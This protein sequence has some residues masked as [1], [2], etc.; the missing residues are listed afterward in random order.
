MRLRIALVFVLTAVSVHAADESVERSIDRDVWIPFLSASTAFDADGFLAVQ[1]PDVVRVS[2]DTKEVYG[3]SRYERE[4]RDGFRR[5]RERRIRRRTD[6]RF[7]DRIS[8]ADLALETGYFR[9]Q[10]TLSNGETRLRYV[11]F[12]IILRKE[13][14]T[15][16]ILVDED[17]AD[18]GRITAEQFESAAPLRI[19]ESQ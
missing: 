7:L 10:T 3:R 13:N 9:S 18:G 2:P 15:W 8:S 16:K 19:P 12:Q 17:T 1:S 6:M 11:R 5:A 4:I 14:G